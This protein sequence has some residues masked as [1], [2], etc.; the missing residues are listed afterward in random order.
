[1]AG[2]ATG[3]SECFSNPTRPLLLFVRPRY[4]SCTARHTAEHASALNAMRHRVLGLQERLD[5]GSR[6]LRG[7]G[8]VGV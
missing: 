7:Q 1:M 5:D 6:C 3:E 2:K 4:T 8:G